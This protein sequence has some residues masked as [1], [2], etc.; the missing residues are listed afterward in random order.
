MDNVPA[1]LTRLIY[2][3]KKRLSESKIL[4]N[5]YVS[6]F[7]NLYHSETNGRFKSEIALEQSR[8]VNYIVRRNFYV[9]R[10]CKITFQRCMVTVARST[11]RCIS[12]PN[13]PPTAGQ[14]GQFSGSPSVQMY[15]ITQG[16]RLPQTDV[17]PHYAVNFSRQVGIALQS[18]VNQGCK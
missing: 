15:C 13:P 7:S 14:P 2:K 12:R 5:A 6:P 9:L 10:L 8:Q 3:N 4:I 1:I 11:V 16:S 18:V 17:T